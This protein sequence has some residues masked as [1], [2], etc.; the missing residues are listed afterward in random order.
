MRDLAVV[1]TA[2]NEARWLQ[3]LLP[4]IDRG[5]GSADFEVVVADIESTDDTREVIA[6]FPF[7]RAVPVVNRGFAHANNV[8]AAT[9]D[10]RYILYLNA[11][12]ELAEGTLADLVAAMDERPEV[13]L[14][15]VRQ[16]N[17][18]GTLLP[19][20]RRFASPGRRLA[21]ALGS[22]RLAPRLGKR[23]LDMELYRTERS[24]EW[25]VGSFMLVRREALESAGAMDERFFFTAEE[26]DFCMRIRG[27]GWDVR[28]LPQ[29]A[30][31]H[32]AGK[33]GLDERFATQLAFAEMQFA[34]KHFGPIRLRAFQAALALNH[35]IRLLSPSAARR[36][37]SRAALDATLGRVGS[38]FAPPPETAMPPGQFARARSGEAT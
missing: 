12:T 15:G 20:M 1:I 23:V 4:T 10:A 19:T 34:A 32:H 16:L 17:A 29:F 8:A 33:R 3:A 35:S 38:P 22:E 2:M 7:V 18:A 11:D 6:A 37:V 28:H 14:A 9:T 13:G 25:T 31:V 5:H 36:R 21:T 27:A 30:I 24:C 26:E